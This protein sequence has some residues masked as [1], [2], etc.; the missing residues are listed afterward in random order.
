MCTRTHVSCFTAYG[1]QT[2]PENH[3]IRTTRFRLKLF[4]KRQQVTRFRNTAKRVLLCTADYCVPI[5]CRSYKINVYD[6][7][8]HTHISHFTTAEIII[9]RRIKISIIVLWSNPN[10]TGHNFKND[11]NSGIRNYSGIIIMIYI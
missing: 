7:I 11:W 8:V 9:F 6:V 1:K 10:T 5:I 3:S 2:L 4:N